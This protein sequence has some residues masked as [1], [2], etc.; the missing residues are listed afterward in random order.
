M[1]NGVAAWSGW[2]QIIPYLFFLSFSVLVTITIMNLVVSVFLEYFSREEKEVLKELEGKKELQRSLSATGRGSVRVGN[3]KLVV[4]DEKGG[5]KIGI[6]LKPMN[7]N[8]RDR[9]DFDM[10]QELVELQEIAIGYDVDLV[11][12][13]KQK[14]EDTNARI[15]TAKV[16]D[17]MKGGD[18]G[19]EEVG[20][21]PDKVKKVMGE[22]GIIGSLRG[23]KRNGGEATASNSSFAIFSH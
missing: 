1:D 5:S 18:E 20:E 7:V 10:D 3:S 4:R 16:L 19:D 21:V 6:K 23:K 12:L 14:G 17:Y 11:Q 22:G 9:I 15:S 2:R 13:R 8:L